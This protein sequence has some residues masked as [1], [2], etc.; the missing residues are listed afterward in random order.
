MGIPSAVAVMRA[1]RGGR[2]R[3]AA[4]RG[5]A[6]LPPLLQGNL[7][8]CRAPQ[9]RVRGRCRGDRHVAPADELRGL[10][11]GRG[12]SGGGHLP[13]PRR[14][15]ALGGR[16]ERG[17]LRDRRGGRLARRNAHMRARRGA[18]DVRGACRRGGAARVPGGA[19]RVR[20]APLARHWPPAHSRSPSRSRRGGTWPAAPACWR[21]PRSPRPRL[22]SPNARSGCWERAGSSGERASVGRVD[23]GPRPA[24]GRSTSSVRS[25]GR[26]WRW[27]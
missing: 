16:G 25:P 17:T 15:R 14:R 22:G 11:H 27:G 2:G 23:S 20:D 5:K 3:A 24:T 9:A 13:R 26:G 4:T 7:G 10:A 1:A 12:Q 8:R 18:R 19:P 21:R 6:R